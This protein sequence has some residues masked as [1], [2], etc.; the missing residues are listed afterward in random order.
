MPGENIQDWSTTAASNS[1][2]DSSIDW[3]EGMARATVNN[4]ARGMMAAHAKQ[5]NLLNGSITTG[6]TA[7]AQTFTSPQGYSSVPTNLCVRLKIGAALTNT[8]TTTLN[9]DSIGAVTIKYPGGTELAAGA[10]VAGSYADFVYNGTN[11][12]LLASVPAVVPTPTALVL[13][14]T[15]TAS[16]S[17]ALNFITGINATYHQYLF[18]ISGLV[19]ASAVDLNA[20]VSSD[21]GANW[22]TSGYS[23]IITQMLGNG[24]LI[25]SGNTSTTILNLSGATFANALYPLTGELRLTAPTVSTVNPITWWTAYH[26]G[27]H[28][29]MW[30]GTGMSA[31][32]TTINAVR[33]LMSSGNIASGTIKLYGVT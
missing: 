15:Q 24:T 28:A 5:R 13:L 4:S 23:L 1:N 20:Q 27:T 22:K 10:L 25:A 21:T 30:Q 18:V 12:I 19:A 33:F 14:D 31:P 17:A 11:W 2:A 26:N 16:N 8:T 6:G 3:S 29:A 9:M 7:D 32:N